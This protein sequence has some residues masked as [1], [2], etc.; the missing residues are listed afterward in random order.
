MKRFTRL[1]FKNK[2]HHTMKTYL[3]LLLTTFFFFSCEDPDPYKDP[4]NVK[5]PPITMEGKNTFGCKV[6]GKVWVPYQDQ[7]GLFTPTLEVIE[8]NGFYRFEARKFIKKEKIDELLTFSCSAIKPEH[9]TD[10]SA[11]FSNLTRIDSCI[12]NEYRNNIVGKI[13]ILF[14]NESSRIISGTFDFPLLINSCKDTIS[15]TDGRFDLKF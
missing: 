14:L 3:I 11:V 7:S 15:I 5:L 8:D 1:S 4:D 2:K 6:N 12:S 9:L 13:Q 10:Y